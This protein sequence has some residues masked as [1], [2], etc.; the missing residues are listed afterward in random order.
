MKKSQSQ[1]LKIA[2][3]GQANVGKSVIFNYFTGLHQHIGNWP[4]KTVEKKE[5]FLFYK[6]Y[7][8]SITDLPGIYSLSTYSLEELVARE[9][10]IEQHPDFIIN[11]IDATNLERNLIFTLQLIELGVPMVVAVNMIDLAK[12]KKININ[13]DKLQELLGV[14]VVATVASQGYGL[15]KL[16][17]AGIE[18]INTSSFEI[19]PIIYGQEVEVPL[20]KIID[21]LKPVKIN[22]SKR[23]LAI[24]L[25]E[26]D[27]EVIKNVPAS[28]LEQ[29]K[30]Y[31]QELENIHGHDSSLVIADERCHLVG[32]IIKEVIK[33]NLTKQISLAER[34][35]NLT[36]HRI[37]G[38]PIMLII[39]SIVF[40]AIFQFGNWFSVW[41]EHPFNYFIDIISPFLGQSLLSVI[42][43]AAL[44]S[45]LAL[46][47]LALPY[48]LP[49]Y[50]VLNFLEAWGYLAR[51]AFLSDNLMHKLG[52]H[53]KASIPLLLGFGCN[54]PACLSCRIM[55]TQRERFI[56]ILLTVFVPCSAVTIII[57]GLVGKFVGIYWALLLYLLD[58][59]VILIL[60]KI[61][62]KV[63]PGEPTE[64][65]MEMPD[66][67]R[68][69]WRNLF[70]LT[71]LRLKKFIFIAAPFIIIFGML[72]ELIYTLGW[73]PYLNTLLSPITVN[74][75]GL[76]LITGSLLIFGAFKKE[77]ILIMLAALV[78]TTNFIEVLTPIQIITLG[79]VSMFYIPCIATIAVLW[80]EFGWRRAIYISLGKIIFA[81]I[82]GGIIYRILNLVW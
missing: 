5:G 73:L 3:V 37:W 2:L 51:V 10:I 67:K 75:L 14:P 40:L 47:Q 63:M 13:L 18:L 24:K 7:N 31:Q 50:L 69:A 22:Y 61:L 36:T 12:K 19:K 44:R 77:L 58:F 39:F 82:L 57:M 70:M 65:I 32:H 66:Y 38:Y 41:L 11:V 45:V 20:N 74:W 16:L 80:K 49:F 56:S 25:L 26:K 46:I 6:N 42:I 34:L 17:D 21:L 59:I 54:V 79:V 27:K 76:P 35:D 9:Y 72:T 28:I 4:G 71:W 81:L 55:E 23:F 48:I 78:G 53:G 33:L 29:A 62:A 15:T 8:F 30:S 43:I 68:P 52:I 64:L 1:K 60:G